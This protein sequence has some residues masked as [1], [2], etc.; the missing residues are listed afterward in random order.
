VT[1][2]DNVN[3]AAGTAS[4]VISSTFPAV[5]GLNTAAPGVTYSGGGFLAGI[6]YAG[7]DVPAIDT[8]TVGGQGFHGAN[9]NDIALT[10]LALHP[11]DNAIFRTSG[12]IPTPV[13]LL[14]FSI[15]E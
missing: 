10:G 15:D 9:I 4:L 3:T 13:E 8:G 6:W 12:N 7:G 11:A 1:I 5:T 14:E 2:A